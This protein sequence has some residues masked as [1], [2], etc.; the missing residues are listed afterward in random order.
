M[1]SYQF[2]AELCLHDDM[3]APRTSSPSPS[4]P[5][6]RS[7][8]PRNGAASAPS[9]STPP[10]ATRPW[11]TSVFLDTKTGSLVLP[12]KAAV[13]RQQEIDQGDRV[14]VSITTR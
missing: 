9:A 8:P 5:P 12:V 1:S 14:T 10:S 4:P 2:T 3:P 13:R 7:A 11:D 6:M